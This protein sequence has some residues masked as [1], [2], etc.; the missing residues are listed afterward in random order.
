MVENGLL[1]VL[2]PFLLINASSSGPPVPVVVPQDPLHRWTLGWLSK[3]PV[4]FIVE[5]ITDVIVYS[6]NVYNLWKQKA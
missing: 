4:F 1:G 5:K 3:L 6:I 2:F